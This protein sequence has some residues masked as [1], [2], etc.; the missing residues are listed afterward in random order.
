MTEPTPSFH[1]WS[2]THI[3][4][5]LV[6]ALVVWAVVADAN[7]R[8]RKS[9]PDAEA[10]NR[11]LG[12]GILAFEVWHNLYWAFWHGK[13]FNIQESLPLHICDLAGLLAGFALLFPNRRLLALMYFW[14]MGLS[15][16]SFLIPVL[17]LGPA[18]LEFWTFWISHLIVVGGAVYVVAAMNFRPKPRDLIFAISVSLAY[19]GFALLL[20]I[21]LGTNYVSLGKNSPPAEFLGPW[22]QRVP[23][24]ALAGVLLMTLTWVPWAIVSRIRTTPSPKP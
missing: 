15:S 4:V 18:H 8:R 17:K 1:M 10:F 6:S 3:I 19:G 14:G 20:D 5:M 21:W 24:L 16:L 11:W 22:P 12:I 2:M 23:L 13:G 7:R 9:P